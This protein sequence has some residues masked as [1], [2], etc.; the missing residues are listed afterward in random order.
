MLRNVNFA[1]V[2]RS[3]IAS[4]R[5]NRLVVPATKLQTKSYSKDSNDSFD[6]SQHYEVEEAMPFVAKNVNL[7]KT[8]SLVDLFVTKLE[9]EGEKENKEEQFSEFEALQKSDKAK[10]VKAQFSKKKVREANDNIYQR[11]SEEAKKLQQLEKIYNQSKSETSKIHRQDVIDM[12][13]KE[14]DSQTKA[15]DTL[16]SFMY[17]SKSPH[18]VVESWELEQQEKEQIAEDF[19]QHK[20]D[21]KKLIK[22][23]G[24]TTEQA[25]RSEYNKQYDTVSL[26]NEMLE[27]MKAISDYSLSIDM[28]RMSASPTS[29]TGD[30]LI[31][32]NNSRNDLKSPFWNVLSNHEKRY[33]LKDEYLED[34]SKNVEKYVNM[35]PEEIEQQAPWLLNDPRWETIEELRK[36]N[37]QDMSETTSEDRSKYVRGRIFDDEALRNLYESL[38]S[39]QF[40]NVQEF[41]ENIKEATDEE[42]LLRKLETVFPNISKDKLKSILDKVVKTIQP[43]YEKYA[44]PVQRTIQLITDEITET[45]KPTIYTMADLASKPKPK[46]Q[47]V[48]WSIRQIATKKAKEREVELVHERAKTLKREDYTSPI[49]HIYEVLRPI[50]DESMKAGDEKSG[51]SEFHPAIYGGYVVATGKR[52]SSIANVKLSPGTGIFLINNKS[53][54]DYFNLSRHHYKLMLPLKFTDTLNQFDVECRVHGGGQTG[55][56]DAIF[57][58]LAKALAKFVPEYGPTLEATGF[59]FRDPRSVERKKFG[60]PKARKQFTFVKR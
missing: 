33:F 27:G 2:L 54:L 50:H 42:G 22:K 1:P 16:L 34:I 57:L 59:L 14:R 45:A 58:G 29:L 40:D 11:D 49:D 56:C 60:Q 15:G 53:Y 31:Q 32:V 55:Q 4:S 28:D 6:P 36:Q 23:D 10:T 20:R 35:T 25:N 21:Y 46:M 39:K 19:K 12:E 26:Q 7:K 38:G 5:S 41:Y 52:K 47:T 24:L 37:I 8:R 48:L 43:K 9:K 13:S 44:T 51:V 30:K 3:A 17:E 18:R